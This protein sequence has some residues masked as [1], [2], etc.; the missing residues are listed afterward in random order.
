MIF[1]VRF[2]LI[3]IKRMVSA[4]LHNVKQLRGFEEF[5]GSTQSETPSVGAEGV[6]G[7]T[8]AAVEADPSSEGLI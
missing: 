2:R 4:F 8:Q 7:S 1:A 5:V 6:S 3:A